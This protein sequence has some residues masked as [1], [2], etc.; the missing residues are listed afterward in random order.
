M[1][2]DKRARIVEV[3]D[4]ASEKRARPRVYLAGP[5]VFFADSEK[6]FQN[7]LAHCERLGMVGLVPSDGLWMS[8]SAPNCDLKTGW[9]SIWT[10]FAVSRSSPSHTEPA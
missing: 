10:V 8:G 4:V 9:S 7:L 2:Q 5:D 3:T 6:I 1:K